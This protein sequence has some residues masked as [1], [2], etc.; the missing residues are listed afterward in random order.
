MELVIKEVPSP[1]HDSTR[2]TAP[3]ILHP[4]TPPA[5]PNPRQ[6]PPSP[7]FCP[8]VCPPVIHCLIFFDRCRALPL[9]VDRDINRSER[10]FGAALNGFTTAPKTVTP[11][12]EG[13]GEWFCLLGDRLLR[14]ASAP[15]VGTAHWHPHRKGKAR[16][17]QFKM[18]TVPRP[19]AARKQWSVWLRR[20]GGRGIGAEV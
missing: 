6:S 7:V 17:C 9:T 14:G 18:I 10:T 16:R 4:R 5:K 2:V 15:R 3:R 1:T 11:R 13:E 20:R 19:T 12:A 8:P